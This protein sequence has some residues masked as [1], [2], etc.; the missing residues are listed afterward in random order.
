[1][2]C[3]MCCEPLSSEESRYHYRCLRKLHKSIRSLH[4]LQDTSEGVRTLATEMAGKM[5][6]QG[7]QPKVSA[8]LDVKGGK[9]DIVEMG[10]EY[11]IKPQTA[12]WAN[13][14]ENE[15]VTMMMARRCNIETP[16]N[17]LIPVA[18][19]EYAYV[20]RRFDRQSANK[21]IAVEDFCQLKGLITEDKYKS[22][23]EQ[24]AGLLSRF[25]SYPKVEA[26]K[27]LKLVLFCYLCGNEDMHLKNYSIIAD[28]KIGWKL[29]PAYD[30]LNT[31]IVATNGDELALP[32]VGKKKNF[33]K[34]DFLD[35]YALKWLRLQ[36]KIVTTIIEEMKESL[37][38]WNYLI[39]KSFLPE[40][41]KRKYVDL[42]NTRVA[43][44]FSIA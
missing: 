26:P 5:S 16:M 39:G 1:M 43:A 24:V 14:P 20:I 10:G 11:I 31:S 25:T 41:Q 36:P 2:K 17:F 38:D 22:S 33:S 28:E 29:S 6:I 4:P 15:H 44:L 40:D 32:L 18:A 21:K 35:H 23:M 7:V 3:L 37:G 30:L 42:L 34:S 9:L 13:V 19:G 8:I 27:L 12:Q